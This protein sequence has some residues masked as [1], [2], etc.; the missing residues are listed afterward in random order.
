M[1]TSQQDL[2]DVADE[3]RDVAPGTLVEVVVLP[4]RGAAL[5]TDS[6]RLAG[7]VQR[8]REAGV[9]TV[10][11]V[12]DGRAEEAVRLLAPPGRG[13][14]GPGRVV[15]WSGTPPRAQEVDPPGG[16][17][18]PPA[19]DDPVTWA[20]RWLTGRS[21]PGTVLRLNEA[22]LDILEDVVAT[23]EGFPS[24]VDDPSWRL[25]VSGFDQ[26]RERDVESW[27]TVANGRS[28]T[29][30]ALE[31]RSRE[32]AAG[33]Y[34]AG[35][36]GCSTEENAVPELVRGPEWT[37]LYPCAGNQEVDLY[38]GEVLQD[39]DRRFRQS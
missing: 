7:A 29:R 11:T 13:A 12:D 20:T 10:L 36:F 9:D 17:S 24:P 37:R 31:E 38:R 33:F 8:L 19:E 15:V 5:S 34:V 21:A 30:G 39:G 22:A 35:I 1:T 2:D 28:G 27:F 26:G 6:D 16:A 18:L 3:P 14:K 4:W 32:S 25:D 23:A